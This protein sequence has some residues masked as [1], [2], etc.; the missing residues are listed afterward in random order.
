VLSDQGAIVAHVGHVA[1]EGDTAAVEDDDIVG[2]LK[3]EFHILLDQQ[4]VVFTRT[5]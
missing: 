2:Q 3:G 4:D 5:L 1:G